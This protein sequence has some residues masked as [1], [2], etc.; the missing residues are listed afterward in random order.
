M[1]REVTF[2]YSIFAD[3]LSKQAK[4]QGFKLKD[5][6]AENMI[7][8]L[9]QLRMENVFTDSMW[10]KVLQRFQKYVIVPNLEP[11]DKKEDTDD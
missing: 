11:I 1:M 8:V 10:D 3:P 6:R 7:F 9:Q 4:K 5:E 2:H